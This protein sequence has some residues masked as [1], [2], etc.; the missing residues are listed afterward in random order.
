MS[1]KPAENNA[2][3]S[4]PSIDEI[5][6]TQTAV[7]IEREYGRETALRMV[8]SAVAELRSE[9]SESSGRDEAVRLID[10]K[11]RTFEASSSRSK[12]KKVINAT[13]VIIHTNLGRSPLSEATI[14]A[15]VQTAS[16]YC[17]VEMDLE[18]G[19]RG[20]RGAS[21]E[22]LLAEV[23]GGEDGLIVNNCAAAALLVLSALAAGGEV[24]VSRGELVEIGGDF[25][26]PD[27]LQR[28]GCRLRE[29]GTTNRT[30]LS[31]YE[32]AIS[33]ETKAILSVHPSNYRIIGFTEKPSLNELGELAH[34]N[35]LLLI[36]DAGSGAL[37]DLSEV[38]LGDEP[39]ISRSISAGADVVCFSGDK[40]VGGVQAG[41]IAGRKE[42]IARVR[43]DPLY[44]ALRA[45]KIVYA[46]VEATLSSFA[47]AAAFDEVPT[48]RMLSMPP[49][50]IRERAAKLL[51]KV[52]GSDV[53]IELIGGESAIGGGAGPDVKLETT[54]IALTHPKLSSDQIAEHFRNWSRPIILRIS[55]DRA[56]I[57]LRTVADDEGS[58]MVDAI[59]Q[60]G[61]G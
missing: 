30:K 23:T 4:I 53:S 14:D 28:S 43:K 47:R 61:A 16:G 12:L 19:E 35:D 38:G 37:V 8:R 60:L 49:A 54:L 5:L 40:L 46:A 27:V 41:L 48:L 57:D 11:L 51:E 3:R 34:K 31:D 33:S 45:D 25:R 42:S 13:G 59:N 58:E 17:N 7:E 50:A 26:V 22:K 6:R 36:E 15:I 39:V 1:Q 20:R 21:A 18:T 32:K 24:I 56:L 55:D 29:V 9:G 44:R 52:Q 2:N 10:E